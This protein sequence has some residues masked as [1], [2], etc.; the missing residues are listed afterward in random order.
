MVNNWL[1]IIQDKLLPP[2]CLICGTHGRP[3]RDL[4]LP[5]QET[6]PRNTDCCRQCA[7]PF[8][9]GTER[10]SGLCGSCLARP[11]AFDQT[12]APYLHHGAI[13]H[14]ISMLKFHGRFQHARIL[15]T[16]LAD[17]LRDTAEILEL[18]LPVPLH[19]GHNCKRGFNHAA[20]IAGVVARE[21]QAPVV[22]RCCHRL[23]HP[24]HQTGL[25]ARQRRANMTGAFAMRRPLSARHA[26]ILDD[27]ITT[28]STTHDLA[29]T[30]K[31]A[32]VVRVDVW[33]CSRA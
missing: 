33:T 23:R 25:N 20:E 18:F 13:R 7:S 31:R 8:A 21:L 2:T 10:H 1:N 12:F 29:R 17:Y 6:L 32:G 9:T 19:P 3:D 30:L 15:G 28:G 22:T 11:P 5:C 4:C 26:A 16:L 24:R 14:L 27:V